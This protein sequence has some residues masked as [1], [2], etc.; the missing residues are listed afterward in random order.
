MWRLYIKINIYCIYLKNG[1]IWKHVSV[2][3]SHLLIA[4]SLWPYGLQQTRL[5]CPSP[6]PRACSNSCPSSWWCHPTISFSVFPFSFCLQSFPAS[7]SLSLHVRWPK[8]WS[9]SI[10]HSMSIQG[11]FLLAL[12][13]L[14]SLRS[15]GLS[16]VFSKTTVQKHQ[17]FGAQP[18]LWS[19]YHI[20][21]WLL[22]KP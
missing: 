17:F 7:G 21:A 9:F 22:K 12:N 19:N 10:S 11:L 20:H 8:L 14:N 13:S 18:S 5:P 15:K 2:Q 6:T 16:R 4:D 3:F 1:K